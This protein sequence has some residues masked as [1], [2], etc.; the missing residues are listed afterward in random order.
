MVTQGDLVN[1]PYGFNPLGLKERVLGIKEVKQPR[2][3]RMTHHPN[4]IWV[5]AWKTDAAT[6]IKVV[7]C[8][9][10]DSDG[11]HTHL[12]YNYKNKVWN[13]TLRFG[14]ECFVLNNR[15]AAAM[16]DGMFDWMI[17]WWTN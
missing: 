2:V 11:H 13:G 5:R 6:H 15:Q 14:D 7:D 10:G 9:F 3:I 12:I 8:E 4:L 1:N 17:D 16:F